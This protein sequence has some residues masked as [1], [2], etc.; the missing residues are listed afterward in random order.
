MVV[1]VLIATEIAKGKK[2]LKLPEN[3]AP[4]DPQRSPWKQV[5][6]RENV[7]CENVSLSDYVK[8]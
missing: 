5:R 4:V 3:P 2:F 7:H 8:G 6:Y 1:P